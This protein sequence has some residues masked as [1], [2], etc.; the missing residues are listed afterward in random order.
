MSLSTSFD[1]ELVDQAVTEEGAEPDGEGP[2]PAPKPQRDRLDS[3]SRLVFPTGIAVSVALFLYGAWERRWIADDGLIVLRTVR[4]LLA[5]NGP[6]FNAGER[7]ETNT[8]VLW[9]YLN[10]LV[11][12]A[13]GARPEYAVL[14]LTLVLD[15][16]AVVF[17]LL[18]AALLWH[19]RPGKVL[20]PAAVLAYIALPPARDFATSGLETPLIIFWLALMWWLLLRWIRRNPLALDGAA[21]KPMLLPAFVAGLGPLVRPELAMMSALIL[22]FMVVV[23]IQRPLRS[24]LVLAAVAGFVPVTYQIF[25]IGYYALPYPNTALAKDATGAKW[26][27]GFLYLTNLVNPYWL[28]LPVALLAIAALSNIRPPHRRRVHRDESEE[29]DEKR[30]WTVKE[31]LGLIQVR[32]FSPT[33][34]VAIFVVSGLLMGV[35]VLRVGGDFM[36]GRVLLPA[37]FALMLPAAALPVRFRGFQYSPLRF[38][39]TIAA[40]TAVAWVGVAGWAIACATVPG[41]PNG[42]VIG[43]SGIVDERGFYVLNTGRSHPIRAEDYI[44]FPRVRA[45]LQTIEQRPDGG[46]LLATNT[47]MNWAVTPP[48]QPIPEGGAEQVVYFLNLGM[49]SMNVGLDVRVI[50]QM[51]LAYPLAAHSQRLDDGRIGHDKSLPPDW[52][53]ADTGMVDKRPWMPPIANE[54][55]VAEAHVA[56]TCPETQ[57][58]LN[59]TRAKLTIRQFISNVIHS[60]DFARYRIDRIPQ[61]DLIRCKLQQPQ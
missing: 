38:P 61:Y 7:V 41:M 23:P 1:D 57:A 27:Q 5:G 24:I 11:T 6:V 54:A 55:W 10:F 40:M 59:S 15:A 36:H 25:R 20:L 43:K 31:V 28:W 49:S 48:P 32:A 58:V 16:F 13:T 33:S 52:A 4:N 8:S 14:G 53:V 50:D 45:M 3:L 35:Y 29:S 18:G 39:R 56:L 47:F 26:H 22:G 2:A 21:L 60:I 46:L 12:W 30:S 51:G 42:T 44:D 37:L 9:T 19:L 34:V 17:A